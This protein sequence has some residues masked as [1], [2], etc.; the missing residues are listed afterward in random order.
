VLFESPHLTVSAPAYQAAIRDVVSRIEATGRV[1]ALHSPLNPAYANQ[2]SANRHAALTQFNLTGNV[3]DAANRVAPVQAAVA[4][5]A[6]AHPQIRIGE[7]DDASIAKAVDDSIY[8]DLHRAELMSYPLALVVLLIAF[9]ALAAAL[10]PLGL[11]MS[12]GPP[13]AAAPP[14]ASGE[15]PAAGPRPAA[16]TPPRHPVAVP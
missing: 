15:P 12:P 9:G 13:P 7:T 14:P 1:I 3:T 8:G 5:A 10:L 4:A 16:D 2:I 11:A 6:A